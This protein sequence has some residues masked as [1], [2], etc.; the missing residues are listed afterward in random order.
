[1]INKIIDKIKLFFTRCNFYKSC[2][3]Y[4]EG[5]LC[6]TQYSGGTPCGIR[7]IKEH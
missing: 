1:M 4:K 2:E 5:L 6:D 7:K 3:L